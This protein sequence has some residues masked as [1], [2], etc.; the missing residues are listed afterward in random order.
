MS[1][2]DKI[3]ADEVTRHG[4][5][6]EDMGADNGGGMGSDGQMDGEMPA[7]SMDGSPEPDAGAETAK[8]VYDKPYQDLGTVLYNA[9]RVSFEDIEQS[10]QR[11]ILALHPD[12]IKSDEQGV[13]LFKTIESVLNEMN[14]PDTDAVDSVYGPG[15]TV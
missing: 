8:P 13:A 14:G 4:F 6:V 10:A 9:L 7:P 3:L 5:L 11:K 1:L 2:F 15:S 12:D